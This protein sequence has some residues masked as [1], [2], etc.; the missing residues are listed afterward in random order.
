MKSMKQIIRLIHINFILARNGL[1]NVVVSL[2]LFAPLRFIVYLNPWNWLRKEKLTR[3]Q[4]LRK[5]L[6]ELGPIFIK[7]GQAL[8]TR[9]DI[10][11]DDIAKELSKLQDKV[12]PFASDIAI[13]ILEQ[14][15][16]KSPYELFAQFD[17]NA[18]ASASMA[19]VH[20]AT[21]KS[22]EDV[23]VK[24]LRPNMRRIIEQDISIMY[25]IARLAD[26]YWPESRRLKPKEIVKEFEHTLLDELD[27]LREAANGAQLR[28]NFNNSPLLYIPEIY[29]DYSRDNILVMERIHGIPVSDVASLR[30]NQINIKKLAERGVEIFF[31]QV[32]RDCF[33]H[34]DMHPGNIF[35]SYKHPQEPQYICIDF[36]I[37]GTLNE[38]DKRYL[39]EN[40]LAFFNRDYRKVAELHVESGWVSRDTRVDEFESAIRTVCEPIFEKPLK[41][42]SFAQVVLR[43]FQVARRFQM[44]VQPQLVLLQKTLLA[45]EGLGRQLYPDLDLWVTAKPFLEKWLRQQIGPKNFFNQ[46]KENLPFFTEQLPHMPKLIFDVLELK[47]AELIAKKNLNHSDVN[48]QEGMIQWNSIGIGVL[49]SFLSLAAFD[50]LDLIDY[51]Q[52]T[53]IALVG[54]AVAGLFVL[55]NRKLRS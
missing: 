40:L 7:F 2:R 28:R 54:A 1:D 44:E 19:Q 41:D 6:E 38:N 21:L 4:A 11:P 26:R 50:Y 55:I 31:T 29:W 49:V 48:N 43:L 34:A 39:A 42:I 25:T 36:G 8:S 9:P 13:S 17:S 15:Y 32:F 30:D 51:Q 22:G 37:I 10:L 18:L 12:P 33:F 46:L 14:A 53:P 52:M 16:G 20:A 5:T 45:V 23:V 27:L 47:K 35:V 3:G 24:I